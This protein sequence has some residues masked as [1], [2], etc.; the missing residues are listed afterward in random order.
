M[1]GDKLPTFCIL[2]ASAKTRPRRLFPWHFILSFRLCT[3]IQY[4][5]GRPGSTP[6]VRSATIRRKTLILGL[7]FGASRLKFL[8][9]APHAK[10]TTAVACKNCVPYRVL[11]LSISVRLVFK[12]GIL[13]ERGT[14]PPESGVPHNPTNGRSCWPSTQQAANS[15]P[16]SYGASTGQH[17][18]I[19]PE[20]PGAC[21]AGQQLK[22]NA[23]SSNP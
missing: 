6:F 4:V 10:Q 16:R 18:M 19:R 15:S 12:L 14:D 11:T 22:T 8:P 7:A 17:G 5:S 2:S 23:R 13:G 3:N 20:Y 9:P 1:S 21:P